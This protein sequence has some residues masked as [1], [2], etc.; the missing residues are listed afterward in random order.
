MREFMNRSILTIGHYPQ[1]MNG[2]Y[3]EDVS[4][5]KKCINEGYING[6]MDETI[7]RIEKKLEDLCKEL[8]SLNTILENYHAR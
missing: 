1:D 4:V 8:K 7:S 3:P 6:Q 5:F 2:Y